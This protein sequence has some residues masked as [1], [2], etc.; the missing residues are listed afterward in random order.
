MIKTSFM[1][2][3]FFYLE[4]KNIRINLHVDLHKSFNLF[5]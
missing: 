4:V 1:E 5:G 2:S 3:L